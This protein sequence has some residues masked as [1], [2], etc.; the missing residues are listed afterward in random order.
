MKRIV[1]LLFSVFCAC[2][3]SAQSLNTLT[4]KEEKQ[5]WVLLFNGT[6]LDGWTSVGMTT[7]AASSSIMKFS[8]SSMR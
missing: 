3:L 1:F 4:P 8:S 2:A 6:N 5:G 7:G